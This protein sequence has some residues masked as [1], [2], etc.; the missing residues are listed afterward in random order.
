VADLRKIRLKDLAEKLRTNKV[1]ACE[2][3]SKLKEAALITEEPAP[4]DD[5]K[6]Y[7]LTPEELSVE[8]RLRRIS[9]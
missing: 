9:K 8:R 6:I 7:Y 1:E 2:R 3:L 4:I 5:F